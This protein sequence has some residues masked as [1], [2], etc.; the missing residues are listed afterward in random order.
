MRIHSRARMDSRF[1][2]E[3]LLLLLLATVAA[4]AQ[5]FTYTNI[6]GT[7]T[8]T[9]YTGP[10]GNVI[11]P[12]TLAGLPVTAIGDS[13]F[14]NF[15]NLASVTLAETVTSLGQWEFAGCTGLTN[16]TFSNNLTN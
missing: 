13:V 2:R 6:G 9:G 5:D 15:T 4:N 11:I 7:I 10:G 16:I 1:L 12:S 14:L 3:G 8:I